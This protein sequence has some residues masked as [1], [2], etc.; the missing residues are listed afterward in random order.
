M[1]VTHVKHSF[2]VLSPYDGGHPWL[3]HCKG[4]ILLLKDIVA[5]DEI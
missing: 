1:H 4:F 2:E 3:K 5:F